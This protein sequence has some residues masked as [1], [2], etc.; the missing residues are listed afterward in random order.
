MRGI[1]IKPKYT[2]R[3]TR[4]FN[5]YLNEVNRHKQLT[6]EEEQTLGYTILKGGH[7]AEKAIDQLVKAN[8]RFV[9]SVAKQYSC[10]G[11]ALED[12]VNEG[13]LGL[14]T[15]ARRYDVTR[16]FRFISFA[17]W[18]IRQAILNALREKGNL[19]RLPQSQERRLHEYNRLKHDLEQRLG[20]QA[21]VDE[22]AEEMS[23]S[24]NDMNYTLCAN[25]YSKSLDAPMGDDEEHCLAD[26]IVSDTTNAEDA[27]IRDSLQIDLT[28]TL[29]ALLT[30]REY[31][32][33]LAYY[34]IGQKKLKYDEVGELVN[35]SGERIRQIV[36]DLN[37]RLRKNETLRRLMVA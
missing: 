26:M 7:E 8:L 33:M 2:T 15:A 31:T 3:D 16:G 30:P 17:V 5:L 6:D 1:N 32:I 10:Q 23:I 4:A 20:R 22:I 28:S 25:N 13:N 18:Y 12:L 14:I 24:A 21:T 29:S 37:G 36:R 35:L 19:V 9:I 34:G 11:L 27:L